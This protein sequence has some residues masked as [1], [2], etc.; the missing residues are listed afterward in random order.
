MTPAIVAA[1]EAGI[2]FRINQY[3]HDPDA[4]SF[5]E[6]AA[7]KLG[8]DA[9]SIF[10]TLVVTDTNKQ[11]AVAIVPVLKSLDMKLTARALQV[12]KLEMADKARVQRVTGYVLGGVSPLGQKQLLP[13]VIDE[14]ANNYP[15]VHVSAGKRGLEIALAPG[16]L[17]A[18]CQARFASIAR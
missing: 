1:E 7:D 8:V 4:P 13:T 5:G 6:E 3:Q 12:K 9:G 10:K 17:A 18:M 16:D 14:S 15:H 11:L 2:Q